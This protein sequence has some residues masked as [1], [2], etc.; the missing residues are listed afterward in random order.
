[1]K[2]V[3]FGLS[4]SSSWGNGHATLW[5]ALC[6]ALGA[7]GHRTIFYE[8]DVPYYATTRDMT[9]IPSCELRLYS[10][11]PEVVE[12]ARGEIADADV[13]MVTSYC[14]DAIA[15]CDLVLE[16]NARIR[17]FYDLDA[18]V[19]LARL[20]RRETVEYLPPYGLGGFDLVLSYTG[21]RALELMR[22]WLGARHVV[23]L[24]GSV[25]PDIHKPADPLPE[26]AADV[27]YLG[28]YAADRQDTLTRLFIEPARLRPAMRFLIGGAQYPQDFPWTGNIHFVRH[29]PPAQHPAF[30]CSGRATLNVTRAPMA[31][32]GFCPSGRMF[33]AAACGVPILTDVWEGL[34][35][36]YSAS[37]LLRCTTGSDVLNALSLSDDELRRIGAAARERTLDEHTAKHRAI[38][39]EAILENTMAAVI[40]PE[41]KQIC[42]A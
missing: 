8:R 37:Q 9:A 13:A 29:L 26:F 30:Y 36:F 1:M 22:D 33:E 25:D 5:R 39:F 16:S 12:S 15:A 42:G 19:T 24:Y 11:W 34:D 35:N 27:S 40:T 38:E 23:P 28:T 4:I 20:R 3:V 32:L 41:E 18:P 21:G 2:L 6:K 31:E 14:P 10:S 17:C 7:R